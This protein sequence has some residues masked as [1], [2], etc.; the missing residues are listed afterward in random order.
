[1]AAVYRRVGH[2]DRLTNAADPEHP[3]PRRALLTSGEGAPCHAVR[4][5]ERGRAVIEHLIADGELGRMAV[6]E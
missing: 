3:H 1:V 4:W 6:F 2:A 5:G